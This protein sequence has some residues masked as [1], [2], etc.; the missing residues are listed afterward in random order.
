MQLIRGEEMQRRHTVEKIGGTS[1]SRVD[2]LIAHGADR[3]SEG[4]RTVSAHLRG[5]GLRRASPTCCSSTSTPAT[6]RL[7][8]FN[9]GDGRRR[10]GKT[11][12][13]HD[14]RAPCASLNASIF[15]RHADRAEADRFITRARA[16]GPRQPPGPAQPVLFGP[17]SHRCPS[18]RGAGD[19]GRARR[20][21]QRPQ[22]RAAAAPP[23]RQCPLRRPVGWGEKEPQPLEA[24]SSKLAALRPDR[25]LPICTGYAKCSEGLMKTYDRG[26]SEITFSRLAAS[27]GRGRPSSTRNTTCAAPIRSLVGV[28]RA[29]PSA[30]PT[31][32]SRISCRSSAWRPFIPARRS[33]CGARHSAAGQAQLRAPPRGH[34]DRLPL[35]VDAAAGRDHRRSPRRIRRWSSSVTTWSTGPVTR[36]A[37]RRSSTATSCAR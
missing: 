19:A 27:P 25:E 16:G 13:R 35:S 20:S 9:E 26:Y 23:R 18:R 6:R 33:A 34:A 7:R 12:A 22:H 30:A 5:V 8:L 1:M 24:C 32:T 21:A 10:S 31:T 28:D 15:G 14:A 37:S 2:E 17:L 29:I 3:R 11:G 36:S 4:R